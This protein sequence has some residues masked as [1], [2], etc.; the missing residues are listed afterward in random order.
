MREMR[1]ENINQFIGAIIDAPNIAV[2]F[3]YCARG[4]LEACI[5]CCS[6]S[7]F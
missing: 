5:N 3:I 2:M 1:H 4:N 7:K 6:K